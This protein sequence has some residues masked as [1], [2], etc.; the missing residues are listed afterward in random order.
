M[1][2]KMKKIIYLL[3]VFACV[4]SLFGCVAKDNTIGETEEVSEEIFESLNG[5]KVIY[6]SDWIHVDIDE[7]VDSISFPGKIQDQFFG[8][9]ITSIELDECDTSITMTESFYK[10]MVQGY[11]SG[12]KQVQVSSIENDY[13]ESLEGS[14]SAYSSSYTFYY[15]ET[16]MKAKGLYTVY[17][18][19]M[20]LLIFS[21]PYD[22]FNDFETIGNNMLDSFE[23]TKK[24][25][26]I[27]K[28]EK[29]FYQI[30]TAVSNENSQDYLTFKN[31]EYNIYLEYPKNWEKRIKEDYNTEIT[32]NLAFFMS[33]SE[34]DGDS[35][36]EN[37]Q[38]SILEFYESGTPVSEIEEIT[39]EDITDM[40][41]GV[42]EGVYEEV[43][44][45]TLLEVKD[46]K[47]DDYMGFKITYTGDGYKSMSLSSLD[48]VKLKV[49]QLYIITDENAYILTYTALKD[50]YSD[51][52]NNFQDMINSFKI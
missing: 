20:Y 47:F 18:C 22:Y 21:V 44:N 13:V 29:T 42:I 10:D 6:P 28:K 52:E 16:R 11:P 38:I 3:I 49:S 2:L 48:D 4:S 8:L 34:N 5:Y 25:E 37:V 14:I 1:Y 23:I 27:Q 15:D 46:V 35:F 41:D 19:Q 40:K 12:A 31:Q 32:K 7:S 33:P 17:G 50:T 43:K 39:P 51:Y 36:Q 9:T 26:I 30:K 45:P 24:A